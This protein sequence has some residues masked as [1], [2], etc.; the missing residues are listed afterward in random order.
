MNTVTLLANTGILLRFSNIKILIDAL[1]SEKTVQFSSVS[2]QLLER[3]S[4][5]EGIFSDIDYM[6]FTHGHPDHYS[7]YWADKF[8]KHHPNTTVITPTQDILNRENVFVL[9]K[10]EEDF[11]LPRLNLICKRIVHDGMEYAAVPNYGFMLTIQGHT[12]SVFGDAPI[13]ESVIKT[14]VGGHTIDTAFVNFPFISLRRGQEILRSMIQ[15]K[16][17]F[18]YHLPFEQDDFNGYIE[19]TKRMA[20]RAKTTL[21]PITL[22]YKELQEAPLL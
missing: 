22:L 12:F 13:N 2:N 6:L 20:E 14:F 16:E 15:P 4:K 21:P 18:A 11:I 7:K 3:I 5:G 17:I 10:G 9:R 1:H 19:T 8:I